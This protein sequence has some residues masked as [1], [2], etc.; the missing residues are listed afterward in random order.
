MKE[1]KIITG[2]RKINKKTVIRGVKYCNER[3]KYL[4][5]NEWRSINIGAIVCRRM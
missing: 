5:K 2:M 3:F 1:I 4:G